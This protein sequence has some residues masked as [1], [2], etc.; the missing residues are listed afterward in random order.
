[1]VSKAKA[2]VDE[3]DARCDLREALPEWGAVAF[4]AVVVRGGLFEGYMD[5]TSGEIVVGPTKHVRVHWRGSEDWSHHASVDIVS[6]EYIGEYATVRAH[7][8][9]LLLDKMRRAR[10]NIEACWESKSLRKLD[11]RPAPRGTTGLPIILRTILLMEQ[12]A[13]ANRPQLERVMRRKPQAV[14]GL[15]GDDEG[16]TGWE[17]QPCLIKIL[18]DAATPGDRDV[19]DIVLEIPGDRDI[20]NQRLA[21]GRDDFERHKHFRET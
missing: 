7:D 12:E 18:Q 1:V 15:K 14:N 5:W 6:D 19:L 20:C 2:V 11:F 10:D 4:P 3:Y 21:L 8:A 9:V 16:R 17:E 13:K